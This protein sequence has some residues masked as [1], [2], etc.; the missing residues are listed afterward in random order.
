MATI[1]ELRSAIRSGIVR[2]HKWRIY[3]DF[4]NYA[5]SNGDSS[6]ASIL[7]RTTNTPASNVGVIDLA[8]GG[9]VLPLPGDR[10]YD[11]FTVTFIGVNDFNVY[12]AFE[13]W[14]EAINGSET[15]V[16]LTALDDFMRDVT[17]T[18]LDA[19]DS[20]T[21]TYILK[22]AWPS[23]IGQLSMDS[24]ALDTYSEFDV[25]FRYVNYQIPNVT[26]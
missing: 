25:T 1:S 13:R 20:V 10:Q 2:Q 22:D 3:F 7:A 6:Q 15:N 24:G 26:N 19:N 16:G 11:E 4:P 17:M 18:L 12:N 9:R 8:W 23:H 21:Q 14:S 5:G